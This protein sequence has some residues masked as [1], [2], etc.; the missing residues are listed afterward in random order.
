[1]SIQS[2]GCPEPMLATAVNTIDTTQ[3]P[4]SDQFESARIP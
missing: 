4:R 2:G 3:M 1:M